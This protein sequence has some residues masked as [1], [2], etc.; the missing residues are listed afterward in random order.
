MKKTLLFISVVFLGTIISLNAQ[1]VSV[2]FQVDMTVQNMRGAFNPDADLIQIRGSFNE[3]GTTDMSDDDSDLI[4]SVTVDGISA[5]STAAY[6]F[7]HTGKGGTWESDPNRELSVGSENLVLDPVYFDREEPPSGNPA[8]V[9]FSVDMTLPTDQG[10]FDP[11]V[12]NVFVAGNFTGWGGGAALLNNTGDDILYSVT[13]DTIKSGTLLFFKFIYTNEET[14]GPNATWESDPNREYFVV[15]GENEFFDFWD[16]TDPNV[17]LG[18]GTYSFTV[19]MS[20]MTEI[21]LFNPVKD[22]VQIRG[23]FNGWGISNPDISLM[24]Q[25]FLNTD[26]WFIDIPFENYVVGDAVR[27]KYFANVIEPD[28]WTETWEKPSPAGGGNREM[29]FEPGDKVLDVHYFDGIHPDWI[30]TGGKNLQVTFSI[31][32]EPALSNSIPFNPETDT[33]KWVSGMGTWSVGQNE[34]STDSPIFTLERVGDSYIYEGTYPI[35]EPSFNTFLYVYQYI[36]VVGENVEEVTEDRGGAGQRFVYRTRYIGQDGPRS[37]PVN[38]W[39]MPK[40]TWTNQQDK[41]QEIDPFNSLTGIRQLDMVPEVYSLEQNYP[42]P[43]NPTTVIRFSIPKSEQVTLKIYNL[44]SQEIVTLLNKELRAGVHEIDFN[45]SS[46]S[47]GVYFY[48][49]NAGSFTSSKKM[50]LLK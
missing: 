28:K 34:Q 42:N 11:N 38:P 44:L 8:T 26:Q 3:W 5:N 13:I 2:T 10:N 23:S 37:F 47:S 21:G 4:Y 49:I 32:M 33:V 30:I 7:F 36:H 24:N 9:T 35:K 39:P 29:L 27:W 19:D 22:S 17:Q 18:N 43:F 14:V 1:T 41:P 15:D 31:D 40:D 46:L 48:S 25:D 16:R 6:K 50:L 12:H 45:A 20:A